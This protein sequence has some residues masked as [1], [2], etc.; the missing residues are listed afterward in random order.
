MARIFALADTLDAM[1]S[2]RPYRAALPYSKICAEVDRMA[3][4]QF[5]PALVEAFLAIPEADWEQLRKQAAGGPP[6]IRIA[7]G[8]QR[9]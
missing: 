7:E 9:P 4:K 2:D 6:Y 5:D 3:G 8:V 1:S